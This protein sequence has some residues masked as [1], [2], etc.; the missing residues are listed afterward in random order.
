[1]AGWENGYPRLTDVEL[2]STS[3]NN[4][5]CNPLDFDSY[6]Y[7]HSSVATDR[8]IL[9]CGGREHANSGGTTSKCILQ[10]KEGQTT[11]FP[12]MK[13]TRAL[14]G[15]AI[16]NDTAYA[17]GGGGANANGGGEATME[18]INIKTD[19]EWTLIDLPF[20][21]NF[22]CLSTTPQ[23]LVI[24]GGKEGGGTAVSKLILNLVNQNQK[25]K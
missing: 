20:R 11:T 16:V 13:K 24:T 3:S 9:S 14:F 4:N 25:M 2:V 22:H 7:G 5:L 8:G 23:S 1:M 21:N 15:L 18:K 17:I 19:T 12:S 10:T 6:Q